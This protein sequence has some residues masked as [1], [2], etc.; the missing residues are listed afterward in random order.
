MDALN[1]DVIF[2]PNNTSDHTFG[3][4]MTEVRNHL[5]GAPDMVLYSYFIGSRS[6][7]FLGQPSFSA[8]WVR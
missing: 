8:V 7:T 5:P 3:I 2:R 4:D 1:P 6:C